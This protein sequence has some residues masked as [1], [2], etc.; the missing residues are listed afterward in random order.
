MARWPS[1]LIPLLNSLIKC[2]IHYITYKADYTNIGVAM[3]SK[4]WPGTEVAG[5]DGWWCLDNIQI[6]D[7][8]EFEVTLC[9]HLFVT[10]LWTYLPCLSAHK[11]L[12]DLS[13]LHTASSRCVHLR[14]SATVF[15][16]QVQ[17]NSR[18]ADHTLSSISE[19]VT[20]AILF[21]HHGGKTK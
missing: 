3:T 12:A 21:F 6:A 4:V 5:R 2:I 17:H 1:Q 11:H 15:M 20:A 14:V 18:D 9:T 8:V 7:K 19:R 16:F 13:T 10:T